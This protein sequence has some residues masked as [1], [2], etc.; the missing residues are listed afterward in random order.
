LARQAQGEGAFYQFTTR[1]NSAWSELPDSPALPALLL[2]VLRPDP[3]GP[4]LARLNAHDQRRLDPMQLPTSATKV[5]GPP[6]PRA[7]RLL[8]LRPWVVLVAGLLLALERWLAR[9]R[10]AL[11]SPSLA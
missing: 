10:D 3:S 1:F 11:T 7:L 5:A 9:R 4:E 2:S 6:A 8:D